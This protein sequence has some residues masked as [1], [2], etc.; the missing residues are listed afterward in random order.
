MTI[1]QV[2]RRCQT[3][4]ATA[5]KPSMARRL[6]KANPVQSELRH[7]AYGYPT[8][9]GLPPGVGEGVGWPGATRPPESSLPGRLG[10]SLGDAC[11]NSGDILT[12]AHALPVELS[13]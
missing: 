6:S 2:E 9:A 11:S 10:L 8:F 1:E 5:P 7:C 13:S 3:V 4:L 12:L